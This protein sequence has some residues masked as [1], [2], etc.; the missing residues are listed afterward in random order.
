[1]NKKATITDAEYQR[2]LQILAAQPQN[3]SGA[4]KTWVL[5]L[6]RRLERLF[7]NARPASRTNRRS[8]R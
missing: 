2:G 7:N 6:M 3:Q 8:V 1:M 4:D 5:H